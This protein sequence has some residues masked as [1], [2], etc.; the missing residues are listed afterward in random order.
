MFLLKLCSLFGGISSPVV[1]P[2]VPRK[3]PAR[4]CAGWKVPELPAWEHRLPL[5]EN[6]G[7]KVTMTKENCFGN[8]RGNM[9][10]PML[11]MRLDGL[12]ET[13]RGLQ[14]F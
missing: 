3:G 9:K 7:F 4:C 11:G 6:K 12:G 14:Y 10:S 13:T 5:N 8:G 1:R 2:G